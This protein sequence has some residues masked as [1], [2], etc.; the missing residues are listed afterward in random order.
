MEFV[1]DELADASATPFPEDDPSI[2]LAQKDATNDGEKTEADSDDEPPIFRPSPGLQFPVYS[3]E[4]FSRFLKFSEVSRDSTSSVSDCDS[5]NG[6]NEQDEDDTTTDDGSGSTVS[7]HE[8]DG[9]FLVREA[10]ATLLY[11]AITPL[12]TEELQAFPPDGL[13]ERPMVRLPPASRPKMAIRRRR[14][15]DHTA[16]T[17]VQTSED[18]FEAHG[19]AGDE[20]VVT[21]A[22]VSFAL[23]HRARLARQFMVD[24]KASVVKLRKKKRNDDDNDDDHDGDDADAYA[25]WVAFRARAQ[26]VLSGSLTSGSPSSPPSLSLPLPPPLSSASSPPAQ[27]RLYYRAFHACPLQTRQLSTV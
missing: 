26:V 15:N 8:H 22:P 20:I 5:E 11:P 19:N 12:L 3:A 14:F 10:V 25:G 4:N 18:Y 17:E 7:D 1:A 24:K 13:E 23:E 2:Y 21:I 27:T 9:E 16:A 6:G